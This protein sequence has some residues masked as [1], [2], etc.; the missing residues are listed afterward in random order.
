MKKKRIKV[1]FFSLIE[2]LKL[3]CLLINCGFFFF[4]LFK[5][6]D[7]QIKLV[8]HNWSFIEKSLSIL[9]F[10]FV[11]TLIDLWQFRFRSEIVVYCQLCLF[12]LNHQHTIVSILS[13]TL[14][15]VTFLFFFCFRFLLFDKN[16]ATNARK[17]IFDFSLPS[18]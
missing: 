13:L 6:S 4:I 10:L 1:L 5:N 18:L 11:L 17:T 9:F 7:F 14:F 12:R 15:I 2:L 16:K 8:Q 3:S